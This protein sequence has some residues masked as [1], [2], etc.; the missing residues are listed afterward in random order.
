MT[1]HLMDLLTDERTGRLRETKLWSNIGKAAMTFAFAVV[2][3]RGAGT[4]WLWA[5]YG[6]VVV[7]HELGAKYLNQQQQKLDKEKPNEN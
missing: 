5:M 7:L 6:G 1:W 2:T 4:E 3:W